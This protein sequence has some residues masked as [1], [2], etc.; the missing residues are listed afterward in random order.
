LFPAELD[1]V[2]EHRMALSEPMVMDVGC[3]TGIWYV[4]MPALFIAI[5]SFVIF[6]LRQLDLNEGIADKYTDQ[7]DVVHC[8]TVAAHV[9]IPLS[10]LIHL[11][12]C[13]SQLE[14]PP[15]LVNEL[16]RCLKPGTSLF[17]N[18]PAVLLSR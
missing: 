17:Q 13:F 11:S 4:H 16:V 12:T 15:K 6:K 5:N 9:S 2:V 3:G 14:D 7:Y 10:V 18:F 1:P 8:R